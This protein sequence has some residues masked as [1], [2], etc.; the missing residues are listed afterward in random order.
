MENP[1][2]RQS[3]SRGYFGRIKLEFDR[4][5]AGTSDEGVEDRVGGDRVFGGGSDVRNDCRS[6]CTC[7]RGSER[8]REAPCP[9]TVSRSEFGRIIAGAT[10][11]PA[12]RPFA[13]VAQ[14]IEHSPSKREV[15][16][17]IPAWGTFQN[18]KLFPASIRRSRHPLRLNKTVM[19]P[20]RTED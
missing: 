7:W 20:K 1:A 8:K 17:S 10:A 15:A 4:V 19:P 13:P 6:S 5:A 12:G 18:L 2:R 11:P 16:G 3:S 14:W 9:L